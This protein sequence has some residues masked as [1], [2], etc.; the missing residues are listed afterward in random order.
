MVRVK[1]A[2]PCPIEDA[3]R[4]GHIAE[5]DSKVGW[6]ESLLHPR[7][8]AAGENGLFSGASRVR[9]P[10]SQLTGEDAVRPLDQLSALIG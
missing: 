6:I 1:T 7:L 9:F 4:S 5:I 8:R 10:V 2:I 3:S